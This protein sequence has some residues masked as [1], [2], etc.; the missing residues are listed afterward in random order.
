MYYNADNTQLWSPCKTKWRGAK[1]SNACVP[2]GNTNTNANATNNNLCIGIVT[3]S[4]MS[5]SS[6]VWSVVT[7][8]VVIP[9]PAPALI[10]CADSRPPFT[11][12]QLSACVLLALPH[13]ISKPLNTSPETISTFYL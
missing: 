2:L 10:L 11:Q 3:M 1:C 12:Q 13:R 6:C 8:W 5:K 4:V 7:V 9:P